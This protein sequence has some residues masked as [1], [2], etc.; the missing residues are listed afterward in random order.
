MATNQA[1]GFASMNGGTSGGNGGREVTVSTG[2]QLQASINAAGSSP[3][4]IRVD[5]KITTGNTGADSHRPREQGQ[6]LDHRHGR[7]CGV[8][9]HRHP[10]EGRSSNL[11]IQNLK[12]HD[13]KAGVGDAISVEGPS[14]NIWID[15]N[16]LYSSMSV[17][18]DYYDG[19]LDIKRGAEYI[20]VSNNHF[21][22]HH[23]V[24]LVGYS[25][26]DTARAT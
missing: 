4:T 3:I 16:E 21:H 20:T 25:D 23:K 17:S 18:K 6:H 14:R 19:L 9:R 15:N 10:R 5:G 7:G 11:I 1:F 2:A 13:V 26:A 12:I 8:R 22:D 24:S